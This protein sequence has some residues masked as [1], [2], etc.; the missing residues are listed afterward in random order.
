MLSSL[1]ALADVASG[2]RSGQLAD[3]LYRSERATTSFGKWSSLPI[4][5]EL[6][7]AQR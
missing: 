1:D 2:R 5:H 7:S 3:I 6:I 4:R